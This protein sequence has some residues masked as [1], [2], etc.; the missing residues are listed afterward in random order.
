MDGLQILDVI[1]NLVIR[2]AGQILNIP[3]DMFSTVENMVSSKIMGS[4]DP[5]VSMEDFYN[6]V[7]TF[8]NIIWTKRDQFIK[9]CPARIVIMQKKNGG[10]LVRFYNE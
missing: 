5:S 2:D 8:S 7:G 4:F 9:D 1:H 10:F 6:Y 3:Q